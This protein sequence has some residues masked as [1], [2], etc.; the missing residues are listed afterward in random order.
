MKRIAYRIDRGHPT[1]VTAVLLMLT[2]AVLRTVYFWGKTLTPLVFWV[3]FITPVAASVL[4]AVAVLF[5]GERRAYLTAVPVAMGVFFFMIKA[6]TFPSRLHTVLCLILYAAVLVLFSLT[7]C[8]ILPTKKLL[9]PLF[10]LPF[11]YHLLIEDMVLYVFA[12]PRPPFFEWLPEL[13]VL[14][15][16]LGLFFLGIA[17]KPKQTSCQKQENMI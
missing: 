3:H 2:A 5:F 1:A 10:G 15:I 16:L 14:C 12:D 17:L 13:S 8:G 7:V 9:Y 11:L 6:F 4:F